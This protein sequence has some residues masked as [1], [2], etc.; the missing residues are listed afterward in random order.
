MTSSNPEV[1]P[2]RIM[3]MAWS[4]APPLILAAAVHFK[5]FDR[6]DERPQTLDELAASSGASSRGL[7]AILNALVGLRF[8]TRD[9]QGRFAPTGES[10]T[11][12][13]STKPAYLGGF[14][15][16]SASDIVPSWL[17]LNDAVQSG[18]PVEKMN[19]PQ[20]GEAF[21]QQLVEPIFN[22]SYPATQAV[23]KVLRVQELTTP[24]KV[25]DIGAGSGVWGIGLAQQSPQISVTALDLPGVLEM[26]RR[27]ASRFG[28]QDRFS[29]LPGDFKNVDFGTGYRFVTIG[30]ILHGEGERNSRELLKK[31]FAALTSGGTVIV[32]EFLLNEDRTGPMMPLLFAVN[33]MVNTEEGNTFTFD[34][35]SSWLAG[36]GFVNPRKLDAGG[37][38]SA[39]LAD[40]P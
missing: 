38:T 4:Y 20:A 10:A 9:S 37:P 11:F 3:E 26:T 36:C 28:L 19:E 13:V 39:I 18:K 15:E 16:F 7:K 14:L 8:L 29:Y 30:H 35:V 6:V 17:R 5:I 12:L 31:S 33:M 2:D 24:A 27:V 34:E 40:K 25:L 22:L 21:F 23:G 32:T 1:T